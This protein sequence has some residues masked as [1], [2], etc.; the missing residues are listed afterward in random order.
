VPDKNAE[1]EGFVYCVGY[2]Q[3][4]SSRHERIERLLARFEFGIGL[5][6]CCCSPTAVAE[7]VLIGRS[8]LLT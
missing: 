1:V 5:V 6:L 4:V 2:P 8:L 3:L 7:A